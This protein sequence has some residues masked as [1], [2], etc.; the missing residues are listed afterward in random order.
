MC[1]TEAPAVRT[2]GDVDRIPAPD[3]GSQGRWPIML[4]ALAR[5]R[6]RL[7][8][9]SQVGQEPLRLLD[10]APGAGPQRFVL[11]SGRALALP[12]PAG[13][14]EAMF[15]AAGRSIAQE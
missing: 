6:E 15:Q 13:N 8:I 1:G 9:P 14:L 10:P 5:V 4:E 7:G 3:P 2:V 12:T 11:S